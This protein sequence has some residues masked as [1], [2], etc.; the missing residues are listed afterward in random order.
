MAACRAG[1]Y[2]HLRHQRQWDTQRD[3]LFPPRSIRHQ[4]NR[5]YLHR[6]YGGNQRGGCRVWPNRV[7]RGRHLHNRERNRF[8]F[9]R[10]Q[11]NHPPVVL[12]R[13]DD[14]HYG[15]RGERHLFDV[16]ANG[17]GF[18]VD[19]ITATTVFTGLLLSSNNV[20][21]G[22]S[23]DT[24]QIALQRPLHRPPLFLRLAPG[25]SDVFSG[26]RIQS[27]RICFPVPSARWI[28]R[29]RSFQVNA[30]GNGNLGTVNA[31]GYYVN[32]GASTIS[33]SPSNVK[34]FFSNGAAVVTFPTSP[35]HRLGFLSLRFDCF[36][37]RRGKSRVAVLFG[38][39]QL[40]FRGF[41][42]RWLRHDRGSAE[43]RDADFAQPGAGSLYFT[44]RASIE[45]ASQLTTSSV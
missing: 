12:S 32:G 37:R 35:P 33:Q 2:A 4:Y 19:P 13:R 1:E 29:T 22:S 27:P 11:R 7:S 34:Y 14:L 30:D 10:A 40:L 31:T 6:G 3:V 41:A 43:L 24:T 15:L 8:G 21:M 38:R 36:M 44:A 45:D 39:W 17:Y 42:N 5:R 18:I 20:F 16:S 28:R 23:T 25:N 26:L 9:D